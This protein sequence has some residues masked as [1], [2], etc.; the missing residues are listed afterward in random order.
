MNNNKK[1]IQTLQHFYKIKNSQTL[2]I[3]NKLNI[4]FKQ[5]HTHINNN[6][7]DHNSIKS[8]TQTYKKNYHQIHIKINPKIPQQ[9]NTTNFILKKFNKKHQK[10]LPTLLQKNNTILNKYT[11]N[12]NKLL[13][14]TRNFI[15]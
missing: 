9:I 13:I 15:I 3:Y 10:H 1:T 4:N 12:K 6:N 8:I 2:I 7:A 14:K 5:I 11:Y